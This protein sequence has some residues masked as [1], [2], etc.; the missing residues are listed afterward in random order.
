[1]TTH[2]MKQRFWTTLVLLTWLVVASPTAASADCAPPPDIEQAL[3]LT[4]TAFVGEVTSLDF[5]GR[6]ATFEV[7]EVWKGVVEERVIVN[8]GMPDIAEL[9]AARAAGEEVFTSGDRS[10][11]FGEVYLVLAQIGDGPILRDGGCSA[12]QRFTEALEA[13][14]PASAHA[15]IAVVEVVPADPPDD[16]LGWAVPAALAAVAVA[17]AAGVWLLLRGKEDEQHEIW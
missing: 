8:G 11:A 2:K 12:T 16:G 14:R 4:D 9:T 3:A 17:A 15:P 7:L 6:V 5:D 10:Y 1:M 13:A